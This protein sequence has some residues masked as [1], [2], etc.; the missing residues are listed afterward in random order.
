M[1][2]LRMYLRSETAELHRNGVKLQ[3]I[4][5]RAEYRMILSS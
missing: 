4:G 3:V 2:L 5:S 1:R